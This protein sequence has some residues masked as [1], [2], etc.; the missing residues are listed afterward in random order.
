[1]SL[2]IFLDDLFYTI[3]YKGLGPTNLHMMN[4]RTQRHY[5]NNSQFK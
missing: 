3:V 2:F 1:M 5:E 4:L